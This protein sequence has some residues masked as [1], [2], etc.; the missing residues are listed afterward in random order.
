[1]APPDYDAFITYRRSDG[2]TVARWLRRELEGF[3]VPKPLRDTFGRRLRIY[4]DTAYERGTSDFYEQNIK[5][6]LTS[7]RFL[8]VVATPDA[9]RRPNG[10]DD[11]IEREVMDFAA[12]PNGSNVIAIRA[13]GEFDAPLPADLN[14]RF[15]NIEIVD[16]RGA[17]RF[18]FLNLHRAARLSAEKLKLVA[19]LLDIPRDQMPALRQEEEKRQQTR[20]GGIVGTTIGVLV[21][22][23]G[24]S[25]VALQSRNQALR[26]AD[27]SMFAAGSMALQ[28]RS[29]R[30]DNA[31]TKRTRGLIINRGCDLIDKFRTT[32]VSEPQITDVVMCRL[33][34]AQERERQQEQDEARKQ[35]AEAIA[36]A[37]QR[38]ARLP[39]LDAAL[40]L[41]EARQAYAEYFLRQDDAS[42]AEAEY[43]KLLED[44]RSLAAA[45]EG[46]AQLIR[47][48]A[49][50]L[51]QLGD[52]H[53]KR[54]DSKEA[55]ASYDS[56]AV[57]VGQILEEKSSENKGPDPETI[58]WLARLHRL[59]GQQYMRL[60]EVDQARERYRRSLAAAPRDGSD[61]V[62]SAIENEM[63][64]TQA[65]LFALER[66][67][68]NASAAQTAK[69]EALASIDRIVKSSQATPSF[70]QRATRL[71]AWLES[72][73]ANK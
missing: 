54:G 9:M 15:P 4:L 5:P 37:T 55:A 66:D 33:E 27:D 50:A 48:Q 42:G 36:L 22:V 40:S 25:V 51:G 24:L 72:Q 32:A 46:R 71:K 59:A 7:S 44:A 16:L 49:E 45:H 73:D 28:A 63:A 52:I 38:H 65:A 35:F 2:N 12:G 67:R 68:G 62:A 17:S 1:M 41:V 47:P 20:L 3:R 69:T 18:W 61:Q 13:V 64:M 60:G 56:A 29:L 70:K 19:P 58:A 10:A 6:A 34:R 11:W 8:L 43:G 39:R 26:A 14:R 53:A 31:S 21:A 23:T 57:S 30:E